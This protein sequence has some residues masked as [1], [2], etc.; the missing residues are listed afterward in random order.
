MSRHKAARPH[1]FRSLSSASLGVLVLASLACT[2]RR[3]A[4]VARSAQVSLE[5]SGAGGDRILRL[6]AAP[7]ARIN[8]RLAPVL[9]LHDGTRIT[10]ASAVLTADSSYFAE[11][12]KAV[13]S[14]QRAR[15]GTLRASVC[16]ADVRVCLS[17]V[18][19]VELPD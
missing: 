7:G 8:A 18:L 12:P 9:E 4:I 10:F 13:L 5:A 2:E 19:D 14:R 3:A 15:G 11:S 17:V 6:H 1:L 16:P